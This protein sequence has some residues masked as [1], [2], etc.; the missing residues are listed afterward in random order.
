MSQDLPKIF[1]RNGILKKIPE[2]V[3]S[4]GSVFAVITDKNLASQ[5]KALREALKKAGLSAHLLILPAGEKTKSLLMLEKV[6]SSLL[7]FGLKR[8]CCL[9]ALG[10]GVIGDLTGFLASIYLRGVTYIAVPT[11]L[12][13]MGDSSIGGKTGIDLSE[14]KNLLGTFYHPRLIIMD[15]LLLKTLSERDFRNGLAEI[16]KHAVIADLQFFKF[17]EKN[18][19]AILGRKPAVLQKI[20]KESVRIKSSIVKKDEKESIKKTKGM[21]RMFV[22][23]GHTVGHALE[24]LSNYTLPHGEAVAIG[25]VAEN[26]LAVGKKILKQT[27]ADRITALLQKFHLPITIPSKYPSSQLEKAMSMDKKTIGGKLHFALPTRIGAVRLFTL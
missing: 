25:M 20:A 27:D 8:D 17:L 1:I 26:R 19:S 23:Y 4:L 21:S 6:A 10:G 7:K 24:K 16:V 15:P 5:G 13:S 12:L 22:N 2:K 14:G 9:I 18:V 3:K 11:T